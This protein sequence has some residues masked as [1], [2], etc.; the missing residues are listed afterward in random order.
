MDE[1]KRCPFCGGKVKMYKR[2]NKQELGMD[3]WV[4]CESSKCPVTP[5]L[6]PPLGTKEEAIEAWNTRAEN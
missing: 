3:Y 4:V 5:S 1:L 2:W 6:D